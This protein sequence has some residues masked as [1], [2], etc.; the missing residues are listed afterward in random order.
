MFVRWVISP[1]VIH[2][3]VITLT[4]DTKRK[5]QNIAAE[6][7]KVLHE[8]SLLEMT[9]DRV[10]QGHIYFGRHPGDITLS[11]A[12]VQSPLALEDLSS[13]HYGTK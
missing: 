8:K 1:L 4:F 5:Q 9:P 12:L 10:L 3:P 11:G 6:V 13:E 7:I 2:L